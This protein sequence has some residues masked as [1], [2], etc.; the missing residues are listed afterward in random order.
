MEV[1]CWTTSPRAKT[2]LFPSAVHTTRHHRAGA[3]SSGNQLL[4]TGGALL[5]NGINGHIGS[6]GGGFSNTATISL[7]IDDLGRGAYRRPH[8]LDVAW[9]EHGFTRAKVES[10]LANLQLHLA[11]NDVNP[12]ILFGV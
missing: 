6:G 7:G 2:E 5:T 1:P 10:L 8:V 4:V 12:F 9:N 11:V 3:G